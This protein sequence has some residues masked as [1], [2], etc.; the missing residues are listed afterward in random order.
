M[1]KYDVLSAVRSG[2]RLHPEGT[3][4]DMDPA[5]AEPLVVLG[6][7]APVG[8]SKPPAGKPKSEPAPDPEKT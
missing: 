6:R 5:E 1:A 7:L 8:K 3:V 4:V 2:G